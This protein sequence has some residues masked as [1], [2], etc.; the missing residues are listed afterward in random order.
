MSI[1]F[2]RIEVGGDE[3]EKIDEVLD[4][5]APAIVEDL[6]AAF[7]SYIGA[8]YALATSHGTAALH[9]A[10]LAIDLKRGDKVLCSINAF[11]SLPEVVRHFDAEPIFIDIDPDTFNIDLN[12]LEAYLAENKSKKLKAVIVSHIAG[13]SVDLERLYE[14]GKTYDVKVIEDASDALGATY[15]GK[16]IGSTGADITCFDF[17]PHLRKNVCNGGMLVSDDEE[18]I[19]RARLLRRHAMVV[20]EESLGYIYDVTDIG[21]QYMISPLDAATIFVQLEKQDD[22]VERQKE[23]ASVFNE[24]LEEAPHIK[25]PV[26]GEEHAYSLYIIK[27]DKNRD[28]FARELS[29]RGIECGLHYIPLHLLSYYKAKYSL[30]VNDFPVALRSYQQVLSIPNYAALSDDEVDEICDAILDVASTRV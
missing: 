10:M 4:G 28:S 16:K 5:E 3:R 13:Q 27:V 12:K 9:L 14:I 15:N 22:I 20:D 30:R 6:E 19:E 2:Y 21:S 29:A 18:I 23:I 25:L 17:S 1:P 24:R 8:S 7:E 26:A 11:P